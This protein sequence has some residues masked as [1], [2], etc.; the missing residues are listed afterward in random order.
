M[1]LA[2]FKKILQR[3]YACP[4]GRY[5]FA[6]TKSNFY[7]KKASV[8]DVLRGELRRVLEET[9]HHAPD[10]W[11]GQGDIYWSVDAE[12]GRTT[13]GDLC[14]LLDRINDTSRKYRHNRVRTRRDFELHA[15]R[16][17]R[18]MPRKLAALERSTKRKAKRA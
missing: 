14:W 7:G 16:V 1:Q 13:G 2:Q 18:D 12:V 11:W 17:L 15:E 8:E 10:D 6:Q 5:R 4:N 3:Y 9:D